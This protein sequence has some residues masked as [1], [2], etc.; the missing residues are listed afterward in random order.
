MKALQYKQDEG[1]VEIEVCKGVSDKEF[2]RSVT[3]AVL[4]SEGLSSEVWSCGGV[5]SDIRFTQYGGEYVAEMRVSKWRAAFE[6]CW[7]D[8]WNFV[9]V[10][11]EGDEL[12]FV[13]K[14]LAPLVGVSRSVG[15]PERVWPTVVK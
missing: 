6:V 10:E 2:E 9:F 12:A 7:G 11:N 5:S 14:Y 4:E 15:V 3:E 1:L 13:L 8:T